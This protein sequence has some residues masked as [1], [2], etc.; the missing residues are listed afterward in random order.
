MSSFL[1]EPWLAYSLILFIH[2]VNWFFLGGGGEEFLGFS[3]EATCVLI[4]FITLIHGRYPYF[5]VN[6]GC[7]G[8]AFALK[9]K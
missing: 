7:V 3:L 5:L 1:F 8:L 9:Q 6:G 2:Y 4:C